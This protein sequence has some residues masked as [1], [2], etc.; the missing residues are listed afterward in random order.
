MLQRRQ[1]AALDRVVALANYKGGVGKTTTTAN[2][3]SFF[4]RDGHRVLAV[5]LDDQNNL[6]TMFG[7]ADTEVDDEGRG[8]VD[9]FVD[10]VPFKPVPV[11]GA[12]GIDVLAGGEHTAELERFMVDADA[13]TAERFAVLLSEVARDYDIVFLDCPPK[14]RPLLRMALIA[15]RHLIIPIRLDENSSKGIIKL[16]NSVA[17]IRD[18][19][20]GFELLGVLRFDFDRQS[21]RYQAEAKAVIEEILGEG[22]TFDAIVGHAPGV[23][24]E[25]QRRGLSAIRQAQQL[26]STPRWQ[27]LRQGKRTPLPESARKI[28]LDYQ[29]LYGE[30]VGRIRQTDSRFAPHYKTPEQS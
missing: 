16:T 21:K 29:Q 5:D 13:A 14:S 1:R 22:L 12:D 15:A 30:V 24:F 27:F 7:Y 28:A 18:E 26:E 3:A 19:N 23:S 20:P 17:E 8:V 2:L 6:S 11:P 10:G 25:E 9:S 4:A